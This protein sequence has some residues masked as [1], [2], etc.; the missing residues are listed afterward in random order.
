MKKLLLS[1]MLLFAILIKAQPTPNLAQFHLVSIPND[2]AY[3]NFTSQIEM[4]YSFNA[5]D[6]AP[7]YK[8][9]PLMTLDTNSVGF[10]SLK[11]TIPS[12]NTNTR[13]CSLTD[14]GLVKAFD[15]SALPRANYTAGDGITITGSFPNYTI[16]LTPLTI[17]TV[18]RTTNS[19]Y[20]VSSTKSSN[21]LYS[22]TCTVT[23]PLL[24]G[25]STATAFLEYSINSGSSW[26]LAN[27]TGNSSGVGVAVAIQ[28]TNGQTGLLGGTIPANALVRIRTTTT[29]SASVGSAIGQ[30]TY[31]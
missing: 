30:E 18:T 23:N 31:R 14:S 10:Y 7:T 15:I 26:V 11:S 19:N 13:L 1:L 5:F 29:G 12:V 16:S 22:I 28:L 24:T 27:Q 21:V 8:V 6:P 3:W 4:L 20:T 2:G 25:S 9:R 17:N